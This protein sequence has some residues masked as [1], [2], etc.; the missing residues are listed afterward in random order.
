MSPNTA[1]SRWWL[2]LKD[3]PEGVPGKELGCHKMC[4]FNRRIILSFRQL[5]I[6]NCREAFSNPG[7]PLSNYKQKLLGSET[8]L[9]AAC[10]HGC[11][12]CPCFCLT[13]SPTQVC[14]GASLCPCPRPPCTLAQP[15]QWGP[16]CGA[17]VP[18]TLQ[19]MQMGLWSASQKSLSDSWCT[20][21][22]S[23]LCRL[24]CC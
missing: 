9:C 21:H 13:C 14:S 3:H 23:W 1:V 24:G 6:T 12:L 22:R 7:L 2:H 5:R 15:P 16:R 18:G 10:T 4:L 17:G 11:L 20:L 8:T 19:T